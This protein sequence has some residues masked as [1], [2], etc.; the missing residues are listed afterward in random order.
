MNW[1]FNVISWLIGGVYYPVSILPEWLQKIAEFIPMTHSLEALRQ[2][3]LAGRG[4][5]SIS[6]QLAALFMWV[7]ICLPLSIFSFMFAIKRARIS[8]SLGHY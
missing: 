3:L 4:I 1:A 6:D 8:G 7:V 5:S 2:S